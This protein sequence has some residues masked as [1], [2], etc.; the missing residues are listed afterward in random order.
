LDNK[1]KKQVLSLLFE[2]LDQLNLEYNI[3]KIKFEEK[4]DNIYFDMLSIKNLEILQSN[5]DQDKRNS[6]FSILN[7][8]ITSS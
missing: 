1:D 8:T 6:L 2:Y 7:K 4:Q 3:I 5:Y